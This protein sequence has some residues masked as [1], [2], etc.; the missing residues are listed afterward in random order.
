MEDTTL[1][2][3]AGAGIA[4]YLLLN[5]SATATPVATVSTPPTGGNTTISTAPGQVPAGGNVTIN[6]APPVPTADPVNVV[7]AKTF[8]SPAPN[9]PGGF[10]GQFIASDGKDTV[11][12]SCVPSCTAGHTPRVVSPILAFDASGNVNFPSVGDPVQTSCSPTPVPL[13]DV[14]AVQLSGLKGIGWV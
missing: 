3:I 11:Y 12:T 5:N 2:L 4:A 13:P 14:P 6:T 10:Q 7:L 9:C 8:E 1:L